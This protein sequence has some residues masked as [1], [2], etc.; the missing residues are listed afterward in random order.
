MRFRTQR[1]LFPETAKVI[2]ANSTERDRNA[3]RK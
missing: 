3:L 1:V 2:D